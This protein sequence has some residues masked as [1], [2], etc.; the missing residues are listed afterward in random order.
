VI[1]LVLLVALASIT[2][3]MVERPCRKFINQYWG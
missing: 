2:Y 1:Y 3:Y